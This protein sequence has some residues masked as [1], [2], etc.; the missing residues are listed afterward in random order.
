MPLR[1]APAVRADHER[2]VREARRLPF[3]SLIKKKLARRGRD[4]IIAA[5][6]FRDALG[7]II[8]D[9]SKLVRGRAGGFPD[10]E[11][12]ADLAQIDVRRSAKAVHKAGRLR[13]D[14]KAPGV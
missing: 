1:Q 12:T 14:A 3:Q 8:D 6:Y 2:D 5:D 11:V 4:Q 9:D 7:R 10:H 13:T